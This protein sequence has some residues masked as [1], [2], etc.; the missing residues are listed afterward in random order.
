M[1]KLIAKKN[2][3]LKVVEGKRVYA[4][5]GEAIEVSDEEYKNLGGAYFE[6]PKAVKK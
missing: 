2:F 5:K 1:A 3:L 4:K 6:K